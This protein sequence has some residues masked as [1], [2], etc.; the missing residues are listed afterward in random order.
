MLPTSRS[1]PGTSTKSS[2]VPSGSAGGRSPRRSSCP[3]AAPRAGGPRRC[4]VRARRS[5]VLPWSMWPA[6]PTTTL[7]RRG[8]GQPVA[9][10]RPGRAIARR[11]RA[12]RSAGR[13]R[14]RRPRP[15]PRG[16]GAPGAQRGRQPRG[17]GRRPRPGR[18][19]AA[20]GRAATRRPRRRA[21]RPRRGARRPDAQP[22]DP[23]GPRRSS[24]AARAI[25]RQTGMSSARPPGAVEPER[26]RDRREDR[27]VRPDRAG[28]RVAA[29]AAPRGPAAHDQPRLRPADQLV[30]A[31]QDDVGAGR[32]AL[33]GRRLVG[34]AERR[35]VEER[36]A[37]PGRR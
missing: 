2:T 4:P 19:T 37:S 22:R 23:L 13:T 32:E 25:V 18:T 12:R 11:R 1:W 33:G 17:D 14:A 34:E 24:L 5:V 15:A 28:E 6:V 16:S 31:E 10:R 21:P 3:A 30:A 36:A 29:H 35:R 9:E 27:L 8:R 20:S 26:R 7:I